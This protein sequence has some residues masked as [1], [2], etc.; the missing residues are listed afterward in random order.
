MRAL[1]VFAVLVAWSLGASP[2]CAEGRFAF[3][4]GVD[5]YAN[6]PQQQQL[7]RPSADARAVAE[8]LR[9]MGYA[10]TSATGSVTRTEFL[11]KFSNFK[12]A[13]QP[14]DMAVVFFA[15]HGVA[16][17]QTN[18]LLPSDIPEPIAGDDRL[19][20]GASVAETD[21]VEDLQKQG[22]RVIVMIIDACRDNPFPK[23]A[24]RS[25]GA[26]RGLAVRQPPQGVFSIYSAGA[27]EKALD[28]LTRSAA[29][30]TSDP[31]PNSVFTRV[32]LREMGKPGLNVLDLAENLREEVSTMAETIG[33]QQTPGVYH[34]IRNVRQVFL[35]PP[36]SGQ[37]PP[38][39][40]ASAQAPAPAPAPAP[41]QAP[42]PREPEQQSAASKTAETSPLPLRDPPPT[43]PCASAQ[44]HWQQAKEFNRKE[45]YQEHID[46]FGDCAF[47]SFA[48]MKLQEKVAVAAPTTPPSPPPPADPSPRPACAGRLNPNGV[49]YGRIPTG[50][51]GG[52]FVILGT[53]PHADG[54]KASDRCAAMLANGVPARIVDTDRVPNFSPGYYAVVLGPYVK[55]TASV[56]GAQMKDIVADAYI[57][58]GR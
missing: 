35:M 51:A 9:A 44:A 25:V 4:A 38:P 57:K 50:A 31:D 24:N 46:R 55:P 29:D 14:G 19:I 37:T 58:G 53:F 49:M 52:W 18:Y 8:K 36:V 45:L 40:P 12:R 21:L 15:G 28:K 30:Q 11:V 33:H 2:S 34:Q 54:Y 3:V 7:E 6:L 16:F 39:P 56:V 20:R 1:V 10:V 13:I 26:T 17:E 23:T 43:D 5:V 22:A 42:A 48:R 47:A 32:L 41:A 27:G